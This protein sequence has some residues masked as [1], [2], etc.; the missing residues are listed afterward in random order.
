VRLLRVVQD[1]VSSMKSEMRITYGIRGDEGSPR[2][3]EDEQTKSKVR[4]IAKNER[5]Q[6][7]DSKRRVDNRESRPRGV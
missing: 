4:R 7:L 2:M 5:W 6:E 3:V 1:R